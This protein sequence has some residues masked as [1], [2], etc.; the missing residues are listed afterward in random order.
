MLIRSAG[1]SVTTD[2][3]TLQG[4]TYTKT[5]T[6]ITAHFNI[7]PGQNRYGIEIVSN[8][9]V[10]IRRKAYWTNDT[11]SETPVD[12]PVEATIAGLSGGSAYICNG[13]A[14][15]QTLADI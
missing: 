13:Y 2:P 7:Q 12:T 15:D 1:E 4:V 14:G 10:I 5:E 9:G 3:A 8:L 6:S 11:P